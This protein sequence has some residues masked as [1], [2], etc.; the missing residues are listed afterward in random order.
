MSE[1]IIKFKVLKIFGP[2]IIKTRI[3]KIIIESMNN[4]TLE[5]LNNQKKSKEL[6]AGNTLA[7]NVT[8]EFLLEESWIKNSGWLN[9]L[10]SLSNDVMKILLKKEIKQFNITSSWIV[11]QF[12]NEY[13][14][15]H[16]HSGHLSDVGYLKVPSNFGDTIQKKDAF[17]NKNGQITFAH[18]SKQFLCDATIDIIPEV[19]DLYLFPSYLL[20]AVNPYY[21]SNEERRSVSFNAIVDENISQNV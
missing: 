8:Q 13:N 9:F 19:G 12:Q 15:L 17:R 14:P 18:G 2:Q 10:Y 11:R 5:V 1:E 21:N 6:D 3:P 16:N 20:H 4:Y 7:G